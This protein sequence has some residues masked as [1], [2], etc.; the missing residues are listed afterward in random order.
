MYINAWSWGCLSSGQRRPA[1]DVEVN[2]TA[3]A[4]PTNA[5]SASGGTHAASAESAPNT[6]VGKMHAS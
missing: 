1:E 2:C 4:S 3:Q 5:S 6:I